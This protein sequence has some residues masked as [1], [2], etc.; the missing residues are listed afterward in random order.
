MAANSP[1][2]VRDA[3][4]RDEHDRATGTT[5]RLPQV[6]VVIPCFR[7]GSMLPD[8]VHSVLSQEGVEVRVLIIDDASGDGSADV[9]RALARGDSRVE[10]RV[11]EQNQGNTRTPDEGVRTWASAEYLQVLDADD[12]LT[13]GA[14]ARACAVMDAHPSVGFVY[15]RP[16]TWRAGQPM[17]AAETANPHWVVHPG[18]R[19][20]ERRL[21]VGFNCVPTPT[22]VARTSVQLEVGEL[23]HDIPHTADYEK[24]LR[25][26]LHADIAY[27][28]GVDQGYTRVHDRNFS[29]PYEADGAGVET[30]RQSLDA[31]VSVLQRTG[32]R[33]PDAER[34][35]RRKLAKIALIRAGRSY[36]KGRADEQTVA[37]LVSF[38]AEAVGD[39]S[40]LAAWHTLRLRRWLGPRW[41]RYLRPFVLTAVARR[42][43]QVLRERRQLRTGT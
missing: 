38:A 27:L 18:G 28:R 30:L 42:V 41:A 4:S 8:A 6:D 2:K 3:P 39:P 32:D 34:R 35:L 22:V 16:L 26:A 36:D 13:P 23:N 37:G 17:P 33:L 15:G 29:S 7:Y 21:A 1:G 43:R 19:W 12:V 11:H 40:T 9:A 24:W 10:V 14:L 5:G 20:L 31:A 25:F